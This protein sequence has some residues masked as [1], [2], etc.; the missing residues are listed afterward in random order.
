VFG[1]TFTKTK[2]PITFT[3]TCPVDGWDH[4]DGGC[5]QCGHPPTGFTREHCSTYCDWR[6]PQP[7]SDMCE[8]S[9]QT[10]E[11]DWT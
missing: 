8:A 3:S 11:E 1:I 6:K 5:S 9:F 7:H 10:A 4:A 2:A